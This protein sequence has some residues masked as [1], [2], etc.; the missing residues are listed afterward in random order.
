[1]QS[2]QT[3]THRFE[4]H[5]QP[6]QAGVLA[7]VIHESYTDLVK[8]SDFSEL[9]G[10]VKELAQA[11]KRTEMRVEE[12][13]AAQNRTEQRVEQLQQAQT[14]TET[15]LQN[16]ARQVGGLSESFGGTLESFGIDLIPEVLE[17]KWGLTVESADG[18][19]F[20]VNGRE[21]NI[22]LAVRGTL[23]GRPLVALC[24]IKSNLT[25]VEVYRFLKLTRQIAAT[26]PG[27][28]VRTLFFGYRANQAARDA[29]RSEG[30]YM[31][32]VNGRVL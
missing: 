15:A 12:L 9:K 20:T 19:T 22:D 28:D 17:N 14:S 2:V 1:M 31:V 18:E 26:L 29:I 4:K 7:E 16:L 8:T 24:E 11:Q 25:K 6:G 23:E 10:V 32:F 3:L 21:K 5:F 30:A 13:A 27:Y